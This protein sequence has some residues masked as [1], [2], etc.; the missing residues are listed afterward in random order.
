[1]ELCYCRSTPHTGTSV[2]TAGVCR[3][4]AATAADGG[5]DSGRRGAVT[6]ADGSGD[7]G[8]RGTVT[9]ADGSGDNDRQG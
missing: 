1:M 7:S 3:A 9:V 4:T 5:G 8:R 2:S 6:V